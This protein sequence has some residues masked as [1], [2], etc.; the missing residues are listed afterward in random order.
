MSED[1]KWAC[2]ECGNE[3]H[4]E[5]RCDK[6]GSIRV[7]LRSVLVDLLGEDWKSSFPKED[8]K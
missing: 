2:G 7:V 5:H 4:N 1:Y 8:S 6:C 3:Q